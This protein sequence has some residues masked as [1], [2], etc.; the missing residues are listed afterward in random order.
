MSWGFT[1]GLHSLWALFLLDVLMHGCTKLLIYLLMPH[2][3][4]V[5]KTFKKN[6]S[7]S[8][9]H[10]HHNHQKLTKWILYLWEQFSLNFHLGKE[11]D[12]F[13][14][15]VISL[16]N[17]KRDRW[18]GRVSQGEA[19]CWRWES[20]LYDAAVGFGLASNWPPCIF[21]DWPSPLA[22]H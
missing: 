3:V 4:R 2:L 9:V 18:G 10:G 11:K 21:S 5:C 20:G 12:F 14:F 22:V 13:F 17:V 16:N 15:T 7:S 8:N 6:H 19:G 1:K